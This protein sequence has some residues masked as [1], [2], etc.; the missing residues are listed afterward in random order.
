MMSNGRRSPSIC[1]R[2]MLFALAI[3]AMTPDA[4]NL[5][6]PLLL[7]LVCDVDGLPARGA[8]DGGTGNGSQSAPGRR[9]LPPLE[10]DEED[11]VPG[12]LCV[13]RRPMAG[14]IDP[15]KPGGTSRGDTFFSSQFRRLD[16]LLP[17]RRA[18]EHIGP[19]NHPDLTVHLGRLTC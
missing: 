3:Q 4:Y 10:S 5:S 11:Q 17:Q 1:F 6:S 8:D 2:L 15:R 16:A 7:K 9:A 12:D 14:V 19:W 13:P 18:A